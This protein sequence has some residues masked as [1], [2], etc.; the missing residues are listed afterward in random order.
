M[1]ARV[2]TVALGLFVTSSVWA[3]PAKSRSAVALAVAD[4]YLAAWRMRDVTRGAALLAPSFRARLSQDAL[5]SELSGLSNPHHS[6][7]EVES[8]GWLG[9]NRYAVEVRRNEA[10][11]G[12]ED[13]GGSS[14]QE[15]IVLVKAPSGRWQIAAIGDTPRRASQAGS[16]VS[17]EYG[18]A[19]EKANEAL[20]RWRA[21]G[22]GRAYEI[23]DAQ[24]KPGHG[25]R[26]M[27]RLDRAG[28][29]EKVWRSLWVRRKGEGWKVT[30]LS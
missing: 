12:I 21:Q 2:L 19:L 16:P 8:G 27:V 25:C 4:A 3:A 30:G 7:Y 23:R 29:A 11:T 13:S 5:E 17:P 10:Y 24:A 6:G 22:R 20:E 28:R 18:T 15:R 1:V 26:F 14:S 9:P